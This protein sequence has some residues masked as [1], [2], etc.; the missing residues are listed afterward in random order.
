MQSSQEDID[1]LFTDIRLRLLEI[2][3]TDPEVV[4][5]LKSLLAQLE[6]Y[7]QQLLINSL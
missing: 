4:E 6:D 2:R 3:N 7:V 5:E 1:R